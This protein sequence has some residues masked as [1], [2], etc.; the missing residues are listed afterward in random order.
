MPKRLRSEEGE[1][2]GGGHY[3]GLIKNH[4]SEREVNAGILQVKA[5]LQLSHPLPVL[6]IRIQDPVPF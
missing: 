6:R 2:G 5:I 4:I 1:E 3:S